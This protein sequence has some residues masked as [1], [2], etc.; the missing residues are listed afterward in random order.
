MIVATAVGVAREP[1]AARS[2]LASSRPRLARSRARDGGVVARS[3]S[4]SLQS[5]QLDL[6][7]AAD[8][9]VGRAQLEIS[10]ACAEFGTETRDT[11]CVAIQQYGYTGTY[12]RG[13]A[14]ALA[15]QRS[16]ATSARVTRPSSRARP[17]SPEQLHNYK[18]HTRCMC[19]TK[20][21]S[22]SLYQRTHRLLCA[23]VCCLRAK[24]IR[25]AML[26]RQCASASLRLLPQLC[27]L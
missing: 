22:S 17:T 27:E 4:S 2:P 10:D 9:C 15:S 23:H 11:V 18:R 12:L 16:P 6:L 8:S 14:A 21:R 1:R 24:I 25:L 3:G 5:V 26:A 13:L 19:V 20:S 7:T